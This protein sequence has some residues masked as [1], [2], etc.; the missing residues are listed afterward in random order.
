MSSPLSIAEAQQQLLQLQ[1]HLEQ[2]RRHLEEQSLAQQAAHE[3]G[4]LELQ[5]AIAAAR[6][7]VS[8][9]LAAASPVLRPQRPRIPHPA[10]FSG[11]HGGTALDTWERGLLVYFDYNQEAFS[12]DAERLRFVGTTLEGPALVWWLSHPKPADGLPLTTWTQCLALFHARF[13]PI[14]AATIARKRLY[15]LQQGR[16]SVDAYSSEFYTL[17]ASIPDMSPADQVQHFISGL[18]S[19]LAQRV[20]EKQPTDLNTAS[21]HA[22]QVEGVMGFVSR[23]AAAPTRTAPYSATGAGTAMEL[24]NVSASSDPPPSPPGGSTDAARI[25]ELEA[26]LNVLRSG[27]SSSSSSRPPRRPRNPNS[28]YIQGLDGRTIE[29]RAR[30]RACYKCGQTG[31][32]KDACPNPVALPDTASSPSAEGKQKSQQGK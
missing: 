1:A 22:A 25:A 32:W 30:A 7:S 20:F 24:G 5:R 18:N 4:M 3:R 31:H 29:Q 6:P 13:R 10:K 26:Q 15:A 27:S 12:S 23:D 14:L 9:V 11:S 16:M 28:T 8:P 19:K 21:L 17:L 2:Q